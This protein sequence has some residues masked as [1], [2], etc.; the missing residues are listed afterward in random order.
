MLLV[1]DRVVG[2]DS[3]EPLAVLAA[4]IFAFRKQRVMAVGPGSVATVTLTP[5][6]TQAHTLIRSYAYAPTW[7]HTHMQATSA[8]D[9]QRIMADLRGVLSIPLMQFCLFPRLD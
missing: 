2:C 1:W 5:T 3:L 6:H 7:S 4:A 8:D 9:V